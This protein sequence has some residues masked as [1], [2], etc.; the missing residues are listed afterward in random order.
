MIA[1]YSHKE[2]YGFLSQFYGCKFYE[3][4]VDFNCAEQYMMFKKAVFF[5]DEITAEKIIASSNPSEIKKL[6]REV[7]SFDEKLWDLVKTDI[8]YDGNLLKFSQNT[9]LKHLLLQTGDL[10]LVEAS[11]NDRIWGNGLSIADTRTT[12]MGLWPGRNLL[13]NILMNIRGVLER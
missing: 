5:T 9:S 8:V 4:G 11:P 12:P 13:G 1:F 2:E 7:R 10:Y 6:G 3:D